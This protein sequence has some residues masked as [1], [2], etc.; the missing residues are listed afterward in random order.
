MPNVLARAFEL[1]P[2]C[3]TMKELRRRLAAEGHTRLDEHLG[4]L[5]TQRQLRTL[6]N[7][8]DGQRKRG[9]KAAP[10]AAE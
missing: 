6:F 4:G 2:E 1:A 9:P 10:L 5:G 8:G 7:R 3:G